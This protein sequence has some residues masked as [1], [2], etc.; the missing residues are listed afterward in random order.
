MK[1]ITVLITAFTLAFLTTTLSAQ[2][3][4]MKTQPVDIKKMDIRKADTPTKTCTHGR[5]TLV[6]THD[7]KAVKLNK[8]SASREAVDRKK[9]K[10]FKKKER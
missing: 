4:R 7:M 3:M 2:T 6:K 8:T 1:T 5:K 9:A 10:D